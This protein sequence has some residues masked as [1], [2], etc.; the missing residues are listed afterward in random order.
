MTSTSSLRQLHWMSETC[1]FNKLLSLSKPKPVYQLAR[2]S[3]PAQPLMEVAES[4]NFAV[5]EPNHLRY[6]LRPTQQWLSSSA[7]NL[8]PL[9]PNS[10]SLVYKLTMQPRF[11][12]VNEDQ[13]DAGRLVSLSDINAAQLE[14]D[15][16]LRPGLT[17]L[18]RELETTG[19]SE[20]TQAQIDS[21]D[22]VYVPP[23]KDLGPSVS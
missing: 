21:G 6:V 14:G 20:F 18:L 13:F 10:T 5:I 23:T 4:V 15:M 7:H 11:T 3:D 1:H 17:N 2:H 8:V 12:A 16:A 9:M 19:L 22:V